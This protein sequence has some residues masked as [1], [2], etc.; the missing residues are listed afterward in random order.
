VRQ[1]GAY[2]NDR[3]EDLM[4]ATK[5]LS[6]VLDRVAKVLTLCGLVTY[7]IGGY[8][9]NLTPA[10]VEVTLAVTWSET[11]GSTAGLNNSSDADTWV[12]VIDIRDATLVELPDCPE[13]PCPVNL[14]L[15]EQDGN[16]LSIDVVSTSEIP[17]DN[18]VIRADQ[19]SSFDAF[20]FESNL[21]QSGTESFQFV[22]TTSGVFYPP[23]GSGSITW[24]MDRRVVSPS[25]PAGYIVRDTEGLIDALRDTSLTYTV[26]EFFINN[27]L[28]T[29]YTRT[30]T[31][32]VTKVRV[33]SDATPS[34]ALSCR[35]QV[36]TDWG[37][38]YVAFVYL[39]NETS[40]P[41]SGW[42]VAI[43]FQ[44]PISVTSSWSTVLSGSS[45]ALV[46]GPVDWNQ[47]I[48][49]GQEINFGFQGDKVPGQSSAATVSGSQCR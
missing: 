13:A 4:R 24:R 10:K 9:G 8:A 39:K 30:G 31:A 37:S 17:A 1:V 42:Q 47:I 34:A 29:A 16:G 43:N 33:L 45:P 2:I 41:V 32:Q 40:E 21:F 12:A 26:T 35:Y 7:S 23:Q 15:R 48:Y 44:N 36:A 46:A 22:D 5:S 3:Q 19:R 38:G 49:P 28:Q 14:D 25:L 11:V 6:V 18:P 20:N 27:T